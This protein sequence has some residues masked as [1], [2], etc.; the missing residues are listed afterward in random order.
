MNREQARTL[1]KET[2][3]GGFD[4]GRFTQFI[5]NLLN[6]IDETKAFACNTQ[7]V[8]DAFKPHVSRYE[9]LGTYTAPD[10]R[11]IDIMI[12]SLTDEAKL[13][14]ART[15]LRN[16]VADYL[17]HR[18]RKDAA[19]VAFVSP[20]ES[21]WRFSYIK[22]EYATVEKPTGDVGV[23]ARLTPARR[24]SY[25][26]GPGESCHTAQTRFLDLLQNTQTNPQLE[27]IEEAFSV[28]AVTKE[29]FKAYK[30]LTF[31]V[32]EELERLAAGDG[33][34]G[35]EFAARHISTMDFAKKL[36]GQIVFL[37]FLQKKGWL[38]VPKDGAWGQGPH[39]FLRR[40]AQGEYKRDT[41]IPV[42]ARTQG[43]IDIPVCADQSHPEYANFFNDLLEPL[44][45]DTLATDRG[46]ESLCEQSNCRIPFLNGGLFEPLNGYDWRGTEILLPNRLFTNTEPVEE[47]II[48]T[49][50]LDV[51]DR[52]N[53]TV[54]EAEPLEKEVAIDPEMLGKVFENLLEVKERKSKG[55]YYTPREIVHYMCQES[56]INYLDTAI[57]NQGDTDIP[58][59]AESKGD[60]DIPVCA[61]AG[62][63]TDIPACATAG[64]SIDIPACAE[65]N[66]TTTGGIQKTKRNLPHWTREGSIHWITF[67]LADSLPQEKLSAWRAERHAWLSKNP[68]PWSDDLWQEYDRLFGDRL[69]SWL[70]AG[71][72]SCALARPDVRQAVQDCLLRFDGDRLRL[73]AAVIMPNHVHLLLEPLAGYE[74]SGLLKGIKGA[75]ARKANEILG[76][77]GTAFWMDE[78]YDHIVRSERQ[79]GHFIRYISENP[80]KSNLPFSQFWLYHGEG[81]TDIPACAPGQTASPQT[82]TSVLPKPQTRMSVPRCDI[83][84]LIHSGDQAA[85]Y[86]AARIGGTVSYKARL[87]AS[88]EKN[89]R[90]LDEALAAITVCDPAIGSGAFPVGMM[91]EIVRARTALTPYFN[92]VHDRTPYHFKRHAIQNCLYGVDIDPGA[93]EIAKLR[94]WLSLVV[95]EEDV[96]QI[97]PLP[98]L[99]CKVV[100]GN[101]L[102][103]VEK[104]LFNAELFGR[105]EAVKP[106]YFDETDGEKKRKY[107]QEIDQIIHQLTNGTE[108]FDFEIYFSEVFRHE[109]KG[110][111]VVIGNPPY[112]EARGPAFGGGLKDALQRAL[113][114][115]WPGLNP[116]RY[117]P[118]GADLLVYFL[119]VGVRLVAQTGTVALITQNAWLD[120]EYG[121]K[122]QRF[123]VDRTHVALVV[124]SNFRHFDAA[125][126]PEINTVITFFRGRISPPG[127]YTTFARFERAFSPGAVSSSGRRVEGPVNGVLYQ[128]YPTSSPTLRST[129]WGILLSLDEVVMQLLATLEARAQRLPPSGP[130]RLWVGQGLNLTKDYYL[131]SAQAKEAGPDPE[132]IIP[133]FTAADGAPFVVEDTAMRLVC[134]PAG[135]DSKAKFPGNR[136]VR[137]FDRGSISKRPPIL[138]M[139]R[140][141]GRHFC[142]L[143]PAEA[144]SSSFVEIYSAS[145]PSDEVLYSLWAV[146]NS[147]AMW[148]VREATGRKNLGGGMLKAEAVD[149]KDV[150]FFLRLARTKEIESLA[151][152]LRDREAFD[153]LSEIETPE[154]KTIDDLVFGQLGIPNETRQLIVDGLKR[155]VSERHSK[156]Q[157]GMDGIAR[158]RERDAA[159]PSSEPKKP[160]KNRCG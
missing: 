75:S 160:R 100:V 136:G 34:I 133:I 101:S 37:Y 92:D 22:M 17:K 122:F 20:T 45:Y 1:V 31:E 120:T 111:D 91:Q 137:F 64:G 3:T 84:A 153:T 66:S 19:L 130:C 9:R 116:T 135:S 53:F 83:E 81:D 58:V 48:G 44:F 40:L 61:T 35:A 119:E 147:S 129:K 105:L 69:E 159:P 14:R 139:P 102:L 59:C 118:R 121:V 68:Q 4:R 127:G 8:K 95:D 25:L 26:V 32:K 124:D 117:I 140:G 74:V 56:L 6:R 143:N 7:Y 70:D 50:I 86:E 36:M 10:G 42:C 149:L 24:F 150:P 15:A 115:R 46:H 144:F 132:A 63:D 11:K 141:I 77:A 96:R 55:S 123:L 112:L 12:V 88:I 154:H 30:E 93:V 113:A 128:Q 54:N 28:E 76:S 109:K 71:Y 41:D 103:G 104:N 99:D 146:L 148:L 114:S 43:D 29:F 134:S 98:N 16:F 57:N 156:S 87:P 67:R 79:Y 73:H 106:K 38:G 125:D 27:A 13:T 152:Q 2:F 33:A 158:G 107:R 80:I 60:T 62:G 108:T 52:Y 78:S 131:S 23:E 85:H 89:A 151:Y 142:A 18:D 49:G 110:F 94:L 138:I 65:P 97:K 155:K 39:N 82:G 126:G 72:G 90:L 51:F 5:F 47:G 145:R 157:T 21:A